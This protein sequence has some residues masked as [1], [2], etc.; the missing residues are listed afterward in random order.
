MHD[1]EKTFLHFPGILRAEDNHFPSSKIKI[2][3][4]GR[5]HVVSETIT[6]KLPGIVYSEVWSTEI[7]QLFRGGS[8]TPVT[9]PV[10]HFLHSWDVLT[11]MFLH[12]HFIYMIDYKAFDDIGY[13][14]GE[15]YKPTFLS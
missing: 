8:D 3:A 12:Y 10:I 13:L 4:S 14:S 5:C 6:W 2:N 9:Y 7:L 1:T 15:A 11:I